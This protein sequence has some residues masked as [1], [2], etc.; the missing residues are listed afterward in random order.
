MLNTTK[1]VKSAKEESSSVVP[2]SSYRALLLDEQG[3]E[4]DESG[5]LVLQEKINIKTF[6]ANST[7]EKE[8]KKKLN[9]YLAHRQHV[10]P[11]VPTDGT[12][13]ELEKE[14]NLGL[15]DRI[16]MKNRDSRAKKAFQ[17]VEAGKLVHEA[18][19]NRLKEERKAI[20][21]YSSGRKLIEKRNRIIGDEVDGEG[22]AESKMSEELDNGSSRI[23]SSSQKSILVPPP[24]DMG[25]IPTMEW[26]DEAFLP[27]DVRDNR[28]KSKASALNDDYCLLAIVN[29]KTYKYVQ[30]PVA[31]K[32]LGGEKAVVPLPMFLTKKERKRIRKQTREEREREKRDKMMMGLIAPPEP[33]FK[34][35][36]FMKVLG[37]QAVADPS[38]V[39]MKVLQQM[40]QRQ[41]N[42]EMRNQAAKLTPAERKD[43]K[44][45]KLQEDTSKQVQVA[46]FRINDFSNPKHRFKVDVTA[47]QHFLS[48]IVILCQETNVDTVVVAEGGPKGIRKFIKLM[49][50]KI[51]WDSVLENNNE[52]GNENEYNQGDG[53]ED[54]DDDDDDDDEFNNGYRKSSMGGNICELL[55][56]GSVAK[57]NFTGFRFQEYRTPLAAKKWLESKNVVHY[58]DMAEKTTAAAQSMII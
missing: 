5:N 34:L 3:R 22:E 4:I 56:Q 58:W 48:G 45:K 42:H 7:I 52:W 11:E 14:V 25:I 47:Q 43:K 23:T 29:S 38:K 16:S 37:D 36:N 12:I 10:V 50:E 33:K 51:P 2:K 26:W 24:S 6:I 8:N 53:D 49:T 57:R 13:D 15:D 41:L 27:F 9:P 30:H 1:A 55:W 39:E 17:F 35:S 18:E 54:D 46:L 28:R 20:S 32:P 40:R 21:G 19:E 44:L 31:I